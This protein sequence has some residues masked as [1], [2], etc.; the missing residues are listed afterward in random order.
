MYKHVQNKY[1]EIHFVYLGTSFSTIWVQFKNKIGDFNEEGDFNGG[2]NCKH[3][4]KGNPLSTRY[5]RFFY[6]SEARRYL[7]VT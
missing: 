6:V 4:K 2:V 1:N 7:N 5:Y 3:P